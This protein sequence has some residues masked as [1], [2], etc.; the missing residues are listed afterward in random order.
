[1]LPPRLDQI[2]RFLEN[3]GDA[4]RTNEQ[5]ALLNEL[6]QL[7]DLF[8]RERNNPQVRVLT[9]QLENFTTRMTGPRPGVCPSCL[10]SL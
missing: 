10:R 4:T 7:R 3:V 2:R 6:N 9:E 1:M 5:N 8:E